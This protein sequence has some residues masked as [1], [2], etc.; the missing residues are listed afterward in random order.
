MNAVDAMG[1]EAKRP[2][3]LLPF[4]T[5]LAAG[6]LLFELQ[7][8]AFNGG[9]KLFHIATFV[10]LPLVFSAVTSMLLK[11]RRFLKYWPAF[12][13]YS[14]TLVALFFMWLLDE[15]PARWFGLD[16]K[17]PKGTALARFLMLW[18]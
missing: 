1:A 9:G 14:V 11:S 4:G 6:L 16:P 13:S 8:F 2:P 3:R 17:S 12:F 5:L 7:F 10:G 18:S 15:W